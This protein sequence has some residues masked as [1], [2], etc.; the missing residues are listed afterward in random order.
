MKRFTLCIVILLL[1]G[2][3]LLW[4]GEF[5]GISWKFTNFAVDVATHT[6]TQIVADNGNR[7]DVIVYNNGTYTVYLTSGSYTVAVSTTNGFPL[8][9]GKS[10]SFEDYVGPIYGITFGTNVPVNV[11]GIETE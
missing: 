11:R 4:A 7:K 9:T 10:L 3:V 5:T 1:T 2:A 6:S 8:A